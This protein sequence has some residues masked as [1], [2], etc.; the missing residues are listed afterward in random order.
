MKYSKKQNKNKRPV[1]DIFGWMESG[2]K[3]KKT[4]KVKIKIAVLLL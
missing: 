4:K 1:A 3:E 2:G